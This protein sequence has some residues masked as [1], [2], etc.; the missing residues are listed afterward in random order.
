MPGPRSSPGAR[1]I[2]EVAGAGGADHARRVAPCS[3]SGRTSW[4]GCGSACA[5]ERGS[6]VVL[7]HAEVLEHGELSTRPLRAAEARGR[8]TCSPARA[9]RSW[10]PRSTFHG[11]RY[12]QVDGWPGELDPADVV[13]VVVHSDMRRTGWFSCSHPL[14]DRLHENVVWGMR[15][16]LP[17][18]ADR[19]PAARRAAR[20]D[21]RHPGLLAHRDLPLRLRRLP[22]VVAASTSRSSSRTPAASCPFIVPS[23]LRDSAAP[24]AAWGDAA[25]VVPAVA[26]RAVRR[27]AGARSASTTACAP[28]STSLLALAGDRLLWEGRFQFGDW[29]D[30]AAPPDWPQDASDRP[31]RRRQRAPVPLGRPA[32]ARRR[33]CSAATTTPR[34]TRRWPR[35][36]AR[37][38]SPST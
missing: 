15:G 13:A 7:R 26:A 24:A 9:R 37:R 14:L 35:T 29:L 25:T 8:A 4:A 33:G 1:R 31:R 23:V 38:S 19:L 34:G 21:R 10:E 6:T 5:G 3:T 20:L 30:P 28:G 32:R 22:R 11:F 18:P 17:A 36:C 2:E 27:P 16:Q 12:A